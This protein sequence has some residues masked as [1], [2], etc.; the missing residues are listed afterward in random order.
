MPNYTT[1]DLVKAQRIISRA[2]QAPELRERKSEVFNLFVKGG[3]TLLPELETY[4]QS[5]KRPVEGNYFVRTKQALGTAISHNHTSSNGD[6]GTLAFSWAQRTRDF[7]MALKSGQDNLYNFQA[8][9]ENN[10][11]NTLLDFNT[12]LETLASDYLFNNRS[13]VNVAG[14]YGTFNA[15]NDAYQITSSTATERLIAIITKTVMDVNRYQGVMYDIVCDSVSFIKFAD[16]GAQGDSNATNNSFQYGGV[17]FVHDPALTAKA[18]TLDASY[19]KGFWLAVPEG[20]VGVVPFIGQTYRQGVVTPESN[21][22][23]ILNPLD[24]LQYGVHQY[25][26]RADGTSLGGQLQ[27]NAIH[28]QVHV[29]LAFAKAP[30]TTAN[31]T[32]IQAFALV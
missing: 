5:T 14:V 8:Q 11:K 9:F 12:G 26:D 29:E 7:S 23:A 31:E 32:T 16:F 15:T 30:L 24:S 17:K 18:S 13:G 2:F 27:D 10:L 28:T 4:K 22:G 1:A 19:T 21:F 20:T 3:A 6:S 25:F